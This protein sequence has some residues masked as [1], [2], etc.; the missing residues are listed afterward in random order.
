M[1]AW[2]RLCIHPSISL[3]GC[4]SCLYVC[5]EILE[6]HFTRHAKGG[7]STKAIVFT[8]LRSTVR[9]IVADLAD[10]KGD[11]VATDLYLSCGWFCFLHMSCRG[12]PLLFCSVLFCSVLFCSVLF[13]SVLFCSVLFCSVL[14]CSVLFCSFEVVYKHITKIKYACP[15]NAT[16]GIIRLRHFVAK[17]SSDDDCFG[18]SILKCS[19]KVKVGLFESCSVIEKAIDKDIEVSHIITTEGR[20]L[21]AVCTY[22]VQYISDISCMWGC[23][24][25]IFRSTWK[26]MVTPN[27][28]HLWPLQT[29]LRQ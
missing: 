15:T 13:C 28:A 11:R 18:Y 21:V 29:M 22:D 10:T 3:F 20:S 19:S 27:L 25:A 24:T 9:A 26:V 5:A 1:H 6:E 16:T 17:F 14:F 7:Q 12:F 23:Q 2:L 4:M 8:Q